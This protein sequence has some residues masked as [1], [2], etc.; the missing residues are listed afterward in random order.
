M[1]GLRTDCGEK[2]GGGDG[3][4]IELPLELYPLCITMTLYLT[5]CDRISV[6]GDR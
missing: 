4:E 1:P 3:L 2:R 6:G 5:L